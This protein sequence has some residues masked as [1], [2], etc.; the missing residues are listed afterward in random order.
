MSPD[1]DA[2]LRLLDVEVLTRQRF[3]SLLV[4]VDL[5]TVSDRVLDAVRVLAQRGGLP[6]HLVTT[7]SPGLDPSSDTADLVQRGTELGAL[8][9]EMHVL[10]TD[11]PVD[12][13][14][15]LHRRLPS[16]LLCLATHAR[17]AAVE[18]VLG[19]FTDELLRGH[20][21]PALVVG[22][23]CE[24]VDLSGD[25]VLALASDSPVVKLA[26][27]AR[28]WQSSFGGAL[29]IVE[30]VRPSQAPQSRPAELERAAAWLDAP[31]RTIESWDPAQALVE[32]TIDEGAM[33]IVATHAHDRLTRLVLGSVTWELIQR[34][35][36]PVL[37]VPPDGR[38]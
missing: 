3:E 32:C 26:A 7:T 30:V 36:T 15:A 38:A 9:V 18:L 2:L 1:A 12:A 13:V 28:R 33:V 11:D 25:I 4:P 8:D 27:T 17:T 37:V 34:S 23:A 16:T 10:T 21:G 29:E 31:V 24:P 6:V 19:S 20:V 5:T 22:P 35:A 14:V